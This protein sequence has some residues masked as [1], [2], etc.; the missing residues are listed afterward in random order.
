MCIYVPIIAYTREVYT[1]QIIWNIAK[2][3]T[4]Y[5]QWKDQIYVHNG[6][7]IFKHPKSLLCT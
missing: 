4:F 1:V 6:A 5:T 2:E 7:L 3:R